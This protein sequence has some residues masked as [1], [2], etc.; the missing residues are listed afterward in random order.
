[1]IKYFAVFFCVLSLPHISYGQD[2]DDYFFDDEHRFL[3]EVGLYYGM[4]ISRARVRFFDSPNFQ[5]LNTTGR[6]ANIVGFY[7]ENIAAEER[8][9]GAIIIYFD[10]FY[11][12]TQYQ[13][14]FQDQLQL[15]NGIRT[16]EVESYSRNDYLGIS[17]QGGCYITRR[18][19]WTAGI[20]CRI[21]ILNRGHHNSYVTFTPNDTNLPPFT[22]VV[23]IEDEAIV[24]HKFDVGF[25]AGMKYKTK[26]FSICP[27]FMIDLIGDGRY[28]D[29]GM[30]GTIHCL[31]AP[32]LKI[33]VPLKKGE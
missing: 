10:I 31:S 1:M 17:W 2:N 11:L 18:L 20:D 9:P 33:E 8:R 6:P 30:P 4:G 3:G 21:R 28:T 7:F 23:R 26:N 24:A 25:H 14:L 29:L 12:A 32:Y 5:L 27:S 22:S 13:M 16:F 19:A 15:L